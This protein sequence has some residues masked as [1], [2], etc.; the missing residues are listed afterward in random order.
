MFVLEVDLLPWRPDSM[1]WR[2]CGGC[3]MLFYSPGAL[4]LLVVKG[5]E[6]RISQCKQF[7]QANKG[8]CELLMSE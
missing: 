4:N 5:V 6:S 7:A 8:D 2:C 3:L 1:D